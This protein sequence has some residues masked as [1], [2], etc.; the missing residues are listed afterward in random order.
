MQ[1]QL[2]WKRWKRSF[3]LYLVAKE[4]SSDRQK[5]ALLLHTAW[6][7]LQEVY[8]TLVTTDEL[9]PYREILKVLDDYF[10]PQIKIPFERHVF[11]Q[12]E[13][14]IREKVPVNLYVGC[15]KEPLRVISQT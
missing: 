8:Y 11:R 7:E 4:I 6:P 12:M 10:V 1:T 5:V 15:N 13:Q 3:E 2:R 9:K 14:R